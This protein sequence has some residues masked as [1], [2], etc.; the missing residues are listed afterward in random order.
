[1]RFNI[2]YTIIVQVP[3][4]ANKYLLAACIFIESNIKICSL[5]II[6]W[7]RQ[8]LYDVHI[9]IHEFLRQKYKMNVE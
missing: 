1:M 4:N 7:L 2:D 6:Y 9:S 5:P 3:K 8:K